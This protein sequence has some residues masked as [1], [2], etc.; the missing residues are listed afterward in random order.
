LSPVRRGPR[1]TETLNALIRDILGV[2]EDWYAGRPVMVLE[3]DY[4]SGLFNGDTGL[5]L[6]TPEGLRVFFPGQEGFRSFSPA[7]LPRHET[8]YAMTVHKSQGSEFEHAVLV[9]PETPC[10]IVSRELLYTA[11]TRAKKRFTLIGTARQVVQAVQT[12]VR[13]DSGLGEMLRPEKKK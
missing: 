13:R 7:R 3:N 8:C 12:P 6:P 9:L 4:N 11:L 10:P 2:R 1:G 5:T